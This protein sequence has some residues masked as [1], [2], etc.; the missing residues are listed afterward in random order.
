MK[1]TVTRITFLWV[2]LGRWGGWVRD[3][4][5]IWFLGNSFFFFGQ[6]LSHFLCTRF[7]LN[8]VQIILQKKKKKKKKG[9]GVHLYPGQNLVV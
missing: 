8:H 7:C 2:G 5:G 1:D 9:K 4:F 3:P 6:E